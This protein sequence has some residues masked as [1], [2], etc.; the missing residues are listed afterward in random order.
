[1]IAV[2]DPHA[3]IAAARDEVL[4]AVA[5][6]VDG[7][8]YV[9][10]PEVAAFETAWA[11]WCSV[12]AAVGVSSGTD[13]LALALRA[14][15]VAPGDEVV[16][17]A[18]TAV[19]TWMAV[20]QI[21]AVPVGVDIR[22]DGGIDPER[23]AAAI[24]PGRT[25]AVV[26]VHLFGH[27]CD[28]A[29]LRAVAEPAGISVVEDAAQAHG[30]TVGGRPAGS[31]ASAAAFSFYPTKN[32]GGIGD[33]GAVTSSDPEILD[34]VRQLREYGW[35]ARDDAESLGVNA[36]LDELQAAILRVLLGRL[37]AALERRRAIAARYLE[38]LDGLLR[39]RLPEV[40]PGAVSAWHLFCVHVPE[41]DRFAAALADR[42]VATAVHYAPA[43]H[44]NSAF[45]GNAGEFPVSE[46]HARTALTLPLHPALSDADVESV[47][48]TV[49]ELA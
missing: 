14:V 29:G 17:P 45:G 35:R 22:S 10:G 11:S 23:V 49:R 2:A 19:A 9:L 5:Q 24:R 7:G 4:A 32:L 20:A 30:A 48:S 1:M 33:A 41:R 27:P 39:V 28:V 21:G 26:G 13:A 25:R 6:V 31:L 37:P 43:C 18:M 47:V 15:G 36:R 3:A 34:R 40:R 46:E 42:G 12:P 16:V 44:R 38:G 8:R